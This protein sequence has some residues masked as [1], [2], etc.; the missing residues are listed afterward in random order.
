MTINN[1][2]GCFLECFLSNL[3]LLNSSH[4]THFDTR[5]QTSSCLS[6]CSHSLHLDFHWSVLDHLPYSDHFP[7]LLSPTSYVP[8]PTSHAGALVEQTGVLL[9]LSQLSLFL[10]HPFLLQTCFPTSVTV[11]SAIFTAIPSTSRP[12]TS[13]CVPWWNIECSKN[14]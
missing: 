6:L 3:I 12:Y 10:H 1:S 11:L 5:T 13:K 9:S 4:P 2:R 14:E 7:I 8:L